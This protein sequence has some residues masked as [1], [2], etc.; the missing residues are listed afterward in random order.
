MFEL[1]SSFSR[2]E[3]V[4]SV[5]QFYVCGT[6]VLGDCINDRRCTKN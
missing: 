4:F 6:V 2:D 5:Y 1:A 3:V